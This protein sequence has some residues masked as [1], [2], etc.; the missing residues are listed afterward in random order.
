MK[1]RGR[2]GMAGGVPV[3]VL[4]VAFAV[5]AVG[6]AWAGTQP[7]PFLP[8]TNQLNAVVNVLG[9][10]G[11]NLEAK[12][13]SPPDDQMPAPEGLIGELNAMAQTLAVQDGRVQTAIEAVLGTP[14]DPYTPEFL[15][16]L[17]EV[18]SGAQGIVG[19]VDA[20]LASPPDD[21]RV[22]DALEGV[23]DAAQAIVDTA[24]AYLGPIDAI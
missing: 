10:L 4:V 22:A 20:V 2:R 13:S 3:W 14:P 5:A 8:A 1:G 19:Q 24:N 7:S 9:A 12:L 16:A 21:T 11:G 23:G 17:G 18:R 6:V 15:A